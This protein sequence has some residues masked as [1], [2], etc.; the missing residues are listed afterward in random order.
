MTHF[1]SQTCAAMLLPQNLV[2]SPESISILRTKVK[3]AT[4]TFGEQN[5]HECDN[6]VVL[7]GKLDDL[8]LKMK[9]LKQLNIKPLISR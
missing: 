9:C 5:Q 1:Y 7:A 8:P 2:P 3:K 6:M 4:V